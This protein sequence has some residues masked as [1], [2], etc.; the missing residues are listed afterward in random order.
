VFKGA[1]RL[2]IDTLI[3]CVRQPRA[4]ITDRRSQA[5][6]FKGKRFAWFL[7]DGIFSKFALEV[8]SVGNLPQ[9]RL[10]RRSTRLRREALAERVGD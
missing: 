4:L 10:F 7:Q 2:P 8:H 3:S 5:E 1:D 6:L 9:S